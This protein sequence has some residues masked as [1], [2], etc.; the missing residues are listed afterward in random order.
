[1]APVVWLQ[2]L[3]F[4]MRNLLA[5][6]SDEPNAKLMFEWLLK[7][8]LQPHDK[9]HI[10]HVAMRDQTDAA[11]PASDYFDQVGSTASCVKTGQQEQKHQPFQLCFDLAAKGC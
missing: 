10:L 6:V 3:T 9:L 2:Q 11:L 4:S 8:E 5:A 1:V 7:D